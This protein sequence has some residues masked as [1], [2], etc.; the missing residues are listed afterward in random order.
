[1]L[2]TGTGAAAARVVREAA[3][4][5]QIAGVVPAASY[6]RGVRHGSG[7]G[8]AWLTTPWLDSPSLW[9]LYAPVR[10]RADEVR[11][12]ALA[13]AVAVCLAVAGA[14]RAGWVHGDLQPHH[15]I[16]APDE[17]Q[18]IDWSSAWSPTSGLPPVAT[19]TSGS[20]HQASYELLARSDGLHAAVATVA[21]DVWALAASIWMA[22]SGRWPRNY[23][24]LGIDPSSFTE[25]ELARV[26][27]RHRAPLGRIGH[28]PELETALRTVLDAPEASR[29]TAAELGRNLRAL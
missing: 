3:V 25:T 29:P 13:A 1:M 10:G 4:W 5:E 19:H 8:W 12:Q 20:V 16:L 22:A 21:D 14:H 26:V 2:K 11:E 15:I 7:E 18:L 28:W 24:C 17:A 9:D 23:R 27:S 6:G